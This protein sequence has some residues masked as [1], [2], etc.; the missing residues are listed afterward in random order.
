[1]NTKHDAQ[2]R[3][4]DASNHRHR[5]RQTP[6]REGLLRAPEVARYLGIG[7]RTVWKLRATGR[8]P[9]VGILGTTRFRA[10]DVE[11]LAREGVK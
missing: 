5:H 7:I 3:I 6:D 1:M 9:S 2:P 4:P 11:R 8:L 10:A